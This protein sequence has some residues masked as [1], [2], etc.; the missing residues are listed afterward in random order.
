[1]TD[2]FVFLPIVDDFPVPLPVL[3]LAAHWLADLCLQDDLICPS[4]HSPNMP[5]LPASPLIFLSYFLACSGCGVCLNNCISTPLDP[6][7]G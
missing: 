7:P 4:T 2:S 6:F 1:M 3:G 5:E